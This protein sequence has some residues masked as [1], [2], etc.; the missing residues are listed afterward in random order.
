MFMKKKKIRPKT[1]KGKLIYIFKPTKWHVILI[2]FLYFLGWV[3]IIGAALNYPIYHYYNNYAL[4]YI[5]ET[6]LFI[7]HLIYLYVISSIIIRLFR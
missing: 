5:H 1:T 4:N 6:V 7:A 3:N 2:V